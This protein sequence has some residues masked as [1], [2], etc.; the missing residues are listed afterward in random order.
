[1]AGRRFRHNCLGCLDTANSAILFHRKGTLL[2]LLGRLIIFRI[3]LLP[4]ILY[5]IFPRSCRTPKSRSKKILLPNS[6]LLNFIQQLLR[7]IAGRSGLIE[8]KNILIS[9]F[10]RLLLLPSVQLLFARLRRDLLGLL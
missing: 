10:S 3:S 6:D 4:L 9:L 5:H 2:A 8:G 1:M 7:L